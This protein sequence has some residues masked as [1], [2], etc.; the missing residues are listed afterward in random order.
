MKKLEEGQ[1]WRFIPCQIQSGAKSKDARSVRS[2]K[3]RN[4]R[5]ALFRGAFVGGLEQDAAGDWNVRER[6]TYGGCKRGSF[7]KG[8]RKKWCHWAE[9]HAVSAVSLGTRK[10]CMRGACINLRRNTEPC[11]GPKWFASSGCLW[12]RAAWRDVFHTKQNKQGRIRE[13]RGYE[14]F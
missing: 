3:Q 13:K 1:G 5:W 14:E 6:G 7:M 2:W 12:N 8:S 11:A 4:E 9:I 10:K